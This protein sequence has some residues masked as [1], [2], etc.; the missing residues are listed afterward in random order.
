MMAYSRLLCSEFHARM[1]RISRANEASN[2]KIQASNYARI[3]RFS[4]FIRVWCERT[5]R[6]IF[7]GSA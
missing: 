5:L 3:V 1:A 4:R 2:L 7:I 6:M